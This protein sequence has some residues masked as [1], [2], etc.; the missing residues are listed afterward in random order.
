[1]PLGR[2]GLDGEPLVESDQDPLIGRAVDRYLIQE[3]LG[4]GAMARVYRAKHQF[5]DS[6]FALKILL[7]QIAVDRN[8]A[9]RFRREAQAVSRI[10]HPNVVA[11][12]D[13]G[14]TKEGVTF[15]AMEL[16]RGRTLAAA[17]KQDG[18]MSPARAA[19][20]TKQ[21]ARGLGA[22]QKLGFV[23][24]D[25]KPGN[26]MLVEEQ[27]EISLDGN[28]PAGAPPPQTF[29][30]K[31]TAKV[32]DFGLVRLDDKDDVQR[33][34]R[35]GQ[36]F[37]T[38]AYM[39]PEQIEGG[40][41][42]G[43]AADLYALG[44]ILYE[45][46]TGAPP[47]TGGLHLVLSMHMNEPPKP[48]PEH[49]KLGELALRLLSKKPHQRP[50]D[51]E[52]V[53]TLVEAC[54]VRAP[55]AKR[56]PPPSEGET[57]SSSPFVEIQKTL[58]DVSIAPRE[59]QSA[60]EKSM[61]AISQK[62]RDA[63][64]G[65]LILIGAMLIGFIPGM[66]AMHWAYQ[67]WSRHGSGADLPPVIVQPLPADPPVETAQRTVV[68]AQ[69][70]A[71]EEEAEPDKDRDRDRD[72]AGAETPAPSPGPSSGTSVRRASRSVTV[73]SSARPQSSGKAGFHQLDREL[74]A[75]LDQRGL[76]LSDISSMDPERTAMWS[77]WRAGAT[78]A[79]PQ[80]AVSFQSELKTV[81]K[82]FVIGKPLL[83]Q[84]LDRVVTTLKSKRPNATI[85][86]EYIALVRDVDN[87]SAPHQFEQLAM[88]VAALDRRVRALR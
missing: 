44:V 77:R 23:H 70:A 14:V 50:R 10:K 73:Q 46:L 36:V 32:L 78:P 39:A 75:L 69:A 40:D 2:C 12:T 26:V 79:S 16:L 38:P 68:T 37:G 72:R 63:K 29:G 42:V 59:Q 6:E 25:L 34:T 87:A 83:K 67:L 17:L 57:M 41:N 8:L 21:I 28:V 49:G 85:E 18:P 33:L 56:T 48:I 30:F 82:N 62:L 43:P 20:L 51:P 71:K 24:R 15:L 45:M 64:P 13:F 11:V 58:A 3:Q 74:Q 66:L 54:A 1:M 35:T 60:I 27:R 4:S 86:N 9:E 31:Q 84:K 88:K 76:T 7:G 81:A 55:S 19:D 22:A 52:E 5:L 80:L 47:F 61:I 65:K 53:V